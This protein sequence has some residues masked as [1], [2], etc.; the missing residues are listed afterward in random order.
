MHSLP[1]GKMGTISGRIEARDEEV[2]EEA[3]D[4]GPS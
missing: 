4:G 3:W 1:N 2:R